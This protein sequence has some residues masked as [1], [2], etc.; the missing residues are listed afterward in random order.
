ML[1][2]VAIFIFVAA[3]CLA[4]D[5]EKRHKAL[6]SQPTPSEWHAGAVWRFVTTPPAGKPKLE[7]LT[8]RVTNR[9]G[10]SCLA[11]GGWKDVWRKFIVLGGHVPFGPPIYQVEGQALEINLSGD[12]CDAYDV[13]DG[14]LTGAEF[15]GE[16]RTF[17]MGAPGEILGK[18]RGSHVKQ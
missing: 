7:I 18:V 2:L 14:V 16:R 17:G 1:K 10:V 12:M 11:G 13:I 15:Q 3:V 4:G 6:A 5:I 8:F 9:P